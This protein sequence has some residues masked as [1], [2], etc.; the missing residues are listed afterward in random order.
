MTTK[1]TVKL[2]KIVL[3]YQIQYIL[4][5]EYEKYTFIFIK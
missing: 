3:K 5:K 2:R 4:I 1:H